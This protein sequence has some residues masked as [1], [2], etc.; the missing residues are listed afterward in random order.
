M[1]SNQRRPKALLWQHLY[2]ND[3]VPVIAQRVSLMN[4]DFEPHSHDFVEVVLVLSGYGNHKSLVGEQS[5][6]PGDII[7]LRPGAW[8]VYRACRQLEVYNCC[9]SCS[10]L[11]NELSWMGEEAWL[12]HLFVAK[13]TSVEQHS[14]HFFHLAQPIST[15]CLS[16]LD[17]I[18]I[19]KQ[20]NSVLQKTAILG[21]LL[22]FLTQLAQDM[23]ER[24]AIDEPSLAWKR[25][26][27]MTVLSAKNLLD[28]QLA[29]PWSLETLSKRLGIDRSYLVRLFTAHIG[30]SPIAYLARQRTQQATYLLITTDLPIAAIGA[31]IGWPE[32]RHF[33]RRFKAQVGMSA[34]AYRAQFFA[35]MIQS[36]Q[37]H[38]ATFDESK[39][40]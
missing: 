10:L 37:T 32:P 4:G 33:A 27:P 26:L 1:M 5:L 11:Q 31:A 22:L 9:F 23:G 35:P 28:K 6:A 3:G 19:A 17:T 40:V 21:H 38:Q 30:I 14:I 8:H 36:D 13:A 24:D 29:Y 34:S 15:T 39:Q 12:Q 2:G 7:I 20:T 16:H 18:H 25:A